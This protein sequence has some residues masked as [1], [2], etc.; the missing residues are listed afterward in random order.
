[1]VNSLATLSSTRRI[2]LKEQTK[3]AP[4]QL[5][6]AQHDALRSAVSSLTIERVVGQEGIYTLTPGSTVGAVEIVLDGL[7]VDVLVGL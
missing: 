7:V 4:E 1:M 3:S 5:S 2:D 6:S